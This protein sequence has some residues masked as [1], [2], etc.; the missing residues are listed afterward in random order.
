M[1]TIEEMG[2]EVN[3]EAAMG[4][5]AGVGAEVDLEKRRVRFDEIL[6]LPPAHID[7]LIRA[8]WTRYFSR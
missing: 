5:F 2:F 8:W 1:Q 7:I 6:S 4:I 3:S